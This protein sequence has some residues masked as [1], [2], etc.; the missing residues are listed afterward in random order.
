MKRSIYRQK[1]LTRALSPEQLDQAV[2]ITTPPGWLALS[3]LIG[4]LL[5]GLAWGIWGRV[6]V[7]VPAQGMLVRPGGV[8]RV[9]TL[10]AGQLWDIYVD[11]GDV[12]QEGQVVAA[13][14]PVAGEE[15]DE[16]VSPYAGEVLAVMSSKGDFVQQGGPILTLGPP[17]EE[18]ELVLYVPFA[19]GESVEPGM[20]VQIS[21]V[22]TK[23]EEY[24]FLLGRVDSVADFPS[25]AEGMRHILGTDEM[26]QLF[27]S[28]GAVSA[29]IQVDVKL[30]PAPD[31]PSGYAWS[32]SVGP[33][34]RLTSGTLCS[35]RILVSQRRPISLLFPQLE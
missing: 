35:A 13:L 18:L 12:V 17:G 29:P 8:V 16:L 26:V 28:E 1:A 4:L 5:L 25:T 22:T 31:A 9:V 11:V 7:T 34:F 33:P 24:G 19:T 15:A 10:E 3:G 6:P 2:R 21:P 14:H 27:L 23:K 32:S 30:D 20:T